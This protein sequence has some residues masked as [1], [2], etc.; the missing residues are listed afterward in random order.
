MVLDLLD[1]RRVYTFVEGLTEPLRG[2]VK[3]RRPS[4]LLEA[5]TCMRYL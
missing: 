3:S 2:L 1:V 4:I 5:V